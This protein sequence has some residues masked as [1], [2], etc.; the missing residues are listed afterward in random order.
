M[1]FT[2]VLPYV[3]S[4]FAFFEHQPDLPNHYFHISCAQL[5]VWMSN[6]QKCSKSHVYTVISL[7]DKCPELRAMHN[8][9]TSIYADLSSVRSYGQT[10]NAGILYR[11]K[12]SLYNLLSNHCTCFPL[13]FFL[14]HFNSFVLVRYQCFSFSKYVPVRFLCTG[15][16]YQS[17]SLCMGH[18]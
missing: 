17:T 2:L 9:I 1:P 18:H 7:H 13:R 12:S 15:L 8:D 16:S 14:V 6:G 10:T 4:I 5:L 3:D 11:Y